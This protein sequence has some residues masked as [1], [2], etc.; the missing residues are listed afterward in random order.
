[1]HRDIRELKVAAVQNTRERDYWLKI[2]SEEPV[3]SSFPLDNKKADSQSNRIRKQVDFK[4]EEPLFGQLMGLSKQND[5]ALHVVLTAALTAL[6]GRYSGR[7]DI[8]IAA[9]IYKQAG[10]GQYINTVLPL[11]IRLES[12]VT[13]KQLLGRVKQTLLEA[14]EHQ[15]YP[16]ELLPELLN[17]PWDGA[18]FP[19]FDTALMLENIHSWEYLEHMDL[20]M[21]FKFSRTPRDIKGAAVYDALP[22]R[23][24][25]IAQIVD[26]F[27]RFVQNAL[28]GPDEAISALEILS[29]AEKIQLVVDFNDT[30]TDYPRDKT[31]Y[32]L[33]EEQVEKAPDYVALVGRQGEE[34][35]Q[36]TYRQL[37]MKSVQLA[38]SLIEKGVLADDIVGIM[39]E[40]SIDLIIGILGILKSGG[41]Y[42]TID[43]DYPQ[44]R[45]DYMIKDSN[46]RIMIGSEDERK[47]GRAEKTLASSLPRFPAS[48]SSS[49][50]Y[51][52]YTSGSTGQPKGVVVTHRNVVRLVK[53][54]NFVPLNKE[55]RILQT[56]APVFDATTF[57][58]WG[59]LL[60]KG[61]LV[62]VN[63]EAILNAHRLGV[64]LKDHYINTLWLSAPLFNQLMQENI[65][66]FA[67]LHYLI[68]GGD[69][70]SPD[71]IT[72]V[73][74]RFPGLKIINGYGPTENTT[75][76]TTYLIEK[77]F[78][79]NIPIGRPIANSTAYIYD[80]GS[81]LS[82]IGAIGE[83]YV[84]GDGV[85]LGYLN[86]PE[87]TCEKFKFNRS[88]KSNRT[89]ILYRTGDLARWLNDGNIEFLGRID[90]QV[91][92]RGFRIELGEIENQLRN[93]KMIKDTVVVVQKDKSGDN[94]LCGYIVP[95][96]PASNIPN[97]GELRQ[98]LGKHLPEYMIPLFFVPLQKIPLNRNG[99][100]DRS[101][102][103]E[104][105]ENLPG[106]YIAP[107]D[108]VEEE[109]V[110]MFAD[111]L[112]MK[113]EQVSITTNF[114]K[115]G[116]H[117]LKAVR[118]IAKIHRAFNVG[119]TISQ[120]FKTPTIAQLGEYIKTSQKDKYISIPA[121]EKKEYYLLS[122]IQKRFY[123]LF[124]M[125][126]VDTAFNLV[127][128]VTIEGELDFGRL[129]KAFQ[130]LIE[131]HESL[132]TSFDIRDGEAVQ[133]VHGQANFHIEYLEAEEKN[134]QG[135]VINFLRPFDLKR[136]PLLRAKVVKIAS[137]ERSSL[138]LLHIETH[139]ILSDGT[140]QVIMIRDLLKLYEGK[141]LPPLRIQ[142]KD[143]AEWQGGPVGQA[144]AA[145]YEKY[146]LDR[147]KKKVPDLNIFT[148]FPRP[149]TQSFRGERMYF[150]FER[151]LCRQIGHLV[152]ETGT[153]LF[154]VLLAALN[155]L[156]LKY[157]GNE[158]IVI[159]TPV[160]GR[161]DPELENILGAFINP[162]PLR[163]QPTKEKTFAE[164]LNEV[165]MNTLGAFENQAYPFDDLIEKIDIK[166]DAARNPLFDVDL[167]MLNMGFPKWEI[168]GLTIVPY[169]YDSKVTQMDIALFVSE[170][171]T[172]IDFHL[173]YCTDLFNRETMERFAGYFKDIITIV[174]ENKDRRIDDIDISSRLE[175]T[176]T[177]IYDS[178]ETELDF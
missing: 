134:L 135:L 80:K 148:D 14:I 18:G 11:R 36:I 57:E 178:F 7:E 101:A 4:W 123:I 130:L 167:V 151:E 77:E 62:L 54:T 103:P 5:H 64:L 94:Y 12:G 63:K 110:M 55:T 161:K 43:I 49:L 59:S 87:L 121:V 8:I 108:K 149:T 122:P 69:A 19:F 33:F 81:R 126:G 160:A 82:P 170:Q 106:V 168:E 27:T 23:E 133:I 25:T 131:R 145:K 72:R 109:L 17:V 66:L 140:S 152:E 9:P 51:I 102:L 65:E 138:C 78:T 104:P 83:L 93:H 129:E 116:G 34:K 91:K 58:I 60:N 147:F 15:V 31:I 176:K 165:K 136:A 56:G 40:R 157:T 85:A 1:M 46:A 141:E 44:E 119:L 26:H 21:V 6:L 79:Y 42:L 98:F 163:N 71:H 52:I 95:D 143:V 169:E 24:S 68:V 139:H 90:Q 144:A 96:G 142:Y 159:G 53:N 128:T 118:L 48:D 97:N 41:A 127:E 30:K 125:K 172:G 32:Q 74:R 38:G 158:D 164:F 154:M 86:N 84:G 107:R 137:T 88:Y 75:F 146:W 112:C 13:F 150:A 50:A 29:E 173:Y 16:V 89:Y 115:S 47:S 2:F 22:Y 117:S 132:R 3:K 114:F 105:F 99:K 35:H 92:I 177:D 174:V 10:E 67:P 153:T 155:V 100:I 111:S 166:K 124:A 37:N 175:K 171:E 120:V 113:T 162:L 156:L 39:L 73:K 76:S 45:I 70:L 61:Q 20:G 28:A